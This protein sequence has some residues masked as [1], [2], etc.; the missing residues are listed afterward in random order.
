MK[1]L[2]LCLILTRLLIL[3]TVSSHA[4]RVAECVVELPLQK[5]QPTSRKN[6]SDWKLLK[7]PLQPSLA[8]L[9][10]ADHEQS[11]TQSCSTAELTLKLGFLRVLPKVD[12]L[13]VDVSRSLFS[14]RLF[15]RIAIVPV[16]ATAKLSMTDSQVHLTTTT[17]VEKFPV[18]SKDS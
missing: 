14:S 12:V 5:E 4:A 8:E 7:K 1:R 3:R 2:T 11:Q 15:K 17:W 9:A 6:G 13:G 10:R 18:T 16:V